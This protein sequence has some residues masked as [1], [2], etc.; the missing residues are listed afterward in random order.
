MEFQSN[1]VA[2]FKNIFY[3]SKPK[4]EDTEGCNR[5]NLYIDSSDESVY[6]THSEWDSEDALNNYRNSELFKNTWSKTKLL[7]CAKPRAYSLVNP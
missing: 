3:E 2:D 4:I 1:K 6:Y 7:F 5:V